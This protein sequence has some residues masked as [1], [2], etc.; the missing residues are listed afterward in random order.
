LAQITRVHRGLGLRAEILNFVP[1]A[2]D[3]VEIMQVTL[4]NTGPKPARFSPTAAIPIFARSADNL[5]DHR[6]VSSLLHRILPHKFGVVVKPTMSFDE[7]GHKN[8][9]LL[10]AV[11]GCDGWA[12]APVGTFPTVPSFIGEGGDFDRPKAVLDDLDPVDL[13]E[14]ELQGREAVGALRFKDKK[15]APGQSAVYVLLLA[16]PRTKK[17]STAG[18]SVT[19]APK[20][21]RR[22]WPPIKPFGRTVSIRFKFTPMTRTSTAGPAGSPSNPCCAKSL[23]VLFYRISIMVAAAAAGE[24]SGRTAWRS[25][26]CVPTRRGDFC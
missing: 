3:T 1:A 22:L 19:A 8:N 2:E 20:N 21:A 4:T 17:T 6:Q 10:Y 5:R 9:T 11:V 18:S 25:F 14:A 26:S 23:A 16:L 13:S 24:I 15:L 7:R 12:E